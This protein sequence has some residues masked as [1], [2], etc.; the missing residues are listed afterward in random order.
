MSGKEYDW[1]YF[2]WCLRAG[3]TNKGHQ[4]S[5]AGFVCAGVET[6]YIF[7]STWLSQGGL[8]SASCAEAVGVAGGATDWLPLPSLITAVLI[9]DQVS[10]FKDWIT[11]TNL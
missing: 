1:L 8:H 4:A 6:S 2:S 3:V 10:A 7:W 11:L 9:S 5:S